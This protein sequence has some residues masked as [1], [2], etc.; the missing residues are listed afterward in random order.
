MQ[1]KVEN[2]GKSIVQLEIEVD[3]EKFEQ[4]MQKSFQ[5]NAGK[6]SIPGF[7]KGK[8][9]RYMVEKF[10]GDQVL[11]EDA[12]NAICPDEYDQAVEENDLHP[13]EKP[14]IDIKQIGKGQTFIFT[15]KVTVKPE[16]ELGEYKGVEVTKADALVTDEDVEKEIEKVLDKNSRLVTVEDRPVASGDTAI[17]DFEG[18]IDGVP[19]E[20]GKGTDHSLVI[21]SGTF[22]PGFEDQLIGAAL[23]E[24][25][26]VNVSFP[27]EYGS[28]E[29]AGKPALFRVTVKEIKLKELPALDD[30][31]AKDVSEFDTLEQYKADLRQKMVE[32]AEHKA[33]HEN[34]DNV[35]EKVVENALIE[36]PHVMVEKR[37]DD[38]VYDFSM[39]IR[40]Q[41][42]ELEKY[43]E[44]MGMDMKTFRDQFEK[45]A[46][47]EVKTQLVIEKIGAIEAIV[48]S[49]EDTD[50]EIKKLAESYKQSEEDF[51][52]HLKP[53][54]I[55]YIRSNLVARKTVDFLMENAKLS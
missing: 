21:G 39:R 30:E 36:V 41:G 32:K 6:F 8:A 42:M 17:I 24:E 3:A 34:E 5:K 48:P 13:V 55:E 12:I 15:A 16:V 18:F 44:A 27:E 1:V 51:R 46:E 26:E 19:F 23:G 22:I 7:R 43:L 40:Y 9:P 54:D 33:H 37:V 14:E 2:V 35:V 47:Q 4:G 20:G 10:Y 25:K 53:D 45:R 50:A 52:Q 28:A 49:D 11:Y 29:L 38:L 31:F